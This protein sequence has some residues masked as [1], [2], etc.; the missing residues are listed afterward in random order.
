LKC[1][2]KDQTITERQRGGAEGNRKSFEV[3][4][5]FSL[6]FPAQT[7]FRLEAHP[8]RR[9]PPS[10]E[11][12]T[13]FEKYQGTVYAALSGAFTAS[14]AVPLIITETIRADVTAGDSPRDARR[15]VKM[16]YSFIPA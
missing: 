9:R 16:V 14:A 6:Q 7:F 10:R 15:M 11:P 1:A 2:P 13:L 4:R 8:L 12:W 3:S 5:A